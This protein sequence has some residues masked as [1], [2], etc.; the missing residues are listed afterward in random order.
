MP[1]FDQEKLVKLTSEMRKSVQRLAALGEPKIA[2][3]Y[4]SA[5][6]G[7]ASESRW[8]ESPREVENSP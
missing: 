5:C 7:L 4:P 3:A 6:D 8:I 2:I 1:L